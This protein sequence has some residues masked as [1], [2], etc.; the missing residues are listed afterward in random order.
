MRTG[1]NCNLPFL[2]AD[3]LIY[4]QVW[5]AAGFLEWECLSKI[6]CSC[7]LVCS[8]SSPHITTALWVFSR[9]LNFSNWILVFLGGGKVQ[10]TNVK[11][12]SL[13][14]LTVIIHATMA[15]VV[16]VVEFK[17]L[18]LAMWKGVLLLCLLKYH[19]ALLTSAA[20]LKFNFL[21]RLGASHNRQHCTTAHDGGSE[22]T[23][24]TNHEP[25]STLLTLTRGKT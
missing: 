10:W 18:E 2:W 21:F 1:L 6:L 7:L 3:I 19:C 20:N 11:S 14:S 23:L 17:I 22:D 24:Y 25:L 4:L 12:T 13:H 15:T 8:S 9:G 5:A 16:V